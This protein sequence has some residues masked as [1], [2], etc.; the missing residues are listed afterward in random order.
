MPQ[1]SGANDDLCT[2]AVRPRR[3]IASAANSPSDARQNHPGNGGEA[4]GDSDSNLSIALVRGRTCE[5]CAQI[6]C[7]ARTDTAVE[8]RH[9]PALT[10]L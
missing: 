4:P 1:R 10:S 3:C 2:E 8:S 9:P 6:L 5:A 7:N